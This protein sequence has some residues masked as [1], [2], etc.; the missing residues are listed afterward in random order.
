MDRLSAYAAREA[1]PS[2]PETRQEREEA[3][4]AKLLANVQITVDEPA[5]AP[6][7]E[8]GEDTAESV[9]QPRDTDSETLVEEHPQE[10]ED[11]PKGKA[12][13]EDIK[14]FEIFYEQVMTLTKMQRL[15]VW[16]TMAL[17]V[18]LTNLALLVSRLVVTQLTVA[19]ISIQTDWTMWTRSLP[20]RRMSCRDTQTV[21]ICIPKTRK[22]AFSVSFLRHS[23]RT[24]PYSPLSLFLTS[25]LSCR[26]SLTRLAEPSPG[27][28]PGRYSRTRSKSR[29][30]PTSM[31]RSR[32]CAC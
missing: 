31:P 16:D 26:P 4:L 14:L 3:S 7:H 28:W 19:G 29:I 24:C 30:R 23:R 5:P 1:G 2:S 21:R 15:Q 18:S 9:D 20:L 6:T 22:P 12:I 10:G 32:S 13:P 8:N 17:L 11:K 25:S 27:R